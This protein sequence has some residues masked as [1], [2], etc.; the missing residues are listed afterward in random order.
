MA[1]DQGRV[2]PARP[3]KAWRGVMAALLALLAF[4][5]AL[6]ALVAT[7][8]GTLT[9]AYGWN[10]PND[11]SSGDSAGWALILLSPI[12]LPLFLMLALA[13]S[14]AVYLFVV[15]RGAGHRRE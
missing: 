9:L 14:I 11:G 15:R 12:M 1:P 8:A 10:H 13:V 4:P 6:A 3:S 5:A 7:T 2:P